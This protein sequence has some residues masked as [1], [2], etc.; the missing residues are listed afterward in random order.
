MGPDAPTMAVDQQDALLV[1]SGVDRER[2]VVVG[3]SGIR[4]PREG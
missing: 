3:F 4:L 1:G 2:A